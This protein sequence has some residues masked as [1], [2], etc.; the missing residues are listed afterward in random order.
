MI[1]FNAAV[2][3]LRALLVLLFL[4]LVVAQT[5]I[6]PGTLAHMA[7]EDPEYAYLQWPLLAFSVIELLC[8]Q[9]VIVCTWQLL[10]MVTR[11]QIFS[12]RAFRWVDA[13]LGS[14]ALAWVLL[15]GLFIYIG[16]IATDPGALVLIMGMLL[17]GG[18]LLMLMYV[19]KA[20][21]Q[22]ATSLRTDLEAVI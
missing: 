5:L 10:T 8:V 21:L 9:V 17:A 12:D 20:L 6:M 1:R 2:L 4:G 18:V 15:A 11:D 22:Q 14:M 13:I 7:R 19:M 16:S 3:I